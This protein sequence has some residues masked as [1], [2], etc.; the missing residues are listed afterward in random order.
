MRNPAVVR[1]ARSSRAPVAVLACALALPACADDAPL[2]PSTRGECLARADF[3]APAASPYCL[4]YGVGQSY[5]VIQ[6]YCSPPPGS[7][8]TRYALDF[9]MPM[10]TEI[11]ASRAG[12]VVEL[13]EHFSDDDPMGGHENM[14][15][16]RHEDE[17]ISLYIHMREQGVDVELG[18]FVPQGGHIGW[19]GRSG[20][21]VPHLHFQICIRGGMCTWPNEHTVPVNFSNAVGTHDA[22]GGLMLGETY[23]AGPCS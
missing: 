15:S 12:T 5:E 1:C 7:H 18:D 20:S 8:Q 23:L 4:P 13:R 2:P 14:V 6:S 10:G 19:S 17:T 22:A 16:L 21:S 11:I 3:V 9:F